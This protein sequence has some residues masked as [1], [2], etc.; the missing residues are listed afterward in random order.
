MFQVNDPVRVKSRPQLRGKI[1]SVVSSSYVTVKFEGIIETVG[2]N[3]ERL[4]RD[5]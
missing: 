1:V 2:C 3:T 5:A 4:E